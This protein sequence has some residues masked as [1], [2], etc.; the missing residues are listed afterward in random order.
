MLGMYY[1]RIAFNLPQNGINGVT[2]MFA[3]QEK[4]QRVLKE[5]KKQ[6]IRHCDP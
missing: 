4:K 3:E 6:Y 1:E 2:H 5:K